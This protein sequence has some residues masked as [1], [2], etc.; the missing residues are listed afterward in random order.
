MYEGQQQRVGRLFVRLLHAVVVRISTSSGRVMSRRTDTT[1]TARLVVLECPR[2]TET[3]QSTPRSSVTTAKGEVSESAADLP[4]TTSATRHT[5]LTVQS[6]RHSVKE[7]VL[8]SHQ[9][10]CQK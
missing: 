6:S 4:C 2:I 10:S 8:L 9:C 5:V 1:G 3:R 7:E